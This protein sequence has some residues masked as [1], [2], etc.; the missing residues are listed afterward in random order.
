M[1]KEN[2]NT[3]K[4]FKCE[5]CGKLY[6]QT[7]GLNAHIKK[8]HPGIQIKKNYFK[9]WECKYCKNIFNTKK[10]LFEH[11]KNCVEKLKL[12]HDS[13]GRIIP[14]DAGKKAL[15]TKLRKYGKLTSWNKGKKQTAEH[16]AHIAE[17]T[18][19]YLKKI[20]KFHG[21]RFSKKACEY[22]DKLNSEMGW[23]LQHGMN[24]GEISCGP[25]YIDG[26]DKELNIAFEYDEK[27]HYKDIQNNILKERD[28]KRML[29]I[30][31]RLHCRFFRY[32]E[33]LNFLYEF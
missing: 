20:G 14:K 1:Q 29:Y 5:Y 31:N 23:H 7:S 22:I 30:K 21:A 16:N 32:N 6:S 13:I 12:P 28:L 4:K 18:K 25:Y 15:E 2:S 26:Y 8:H 19:K 17:G 33:V 10:Q 3:I 9:E 24:G 27:K 11:F